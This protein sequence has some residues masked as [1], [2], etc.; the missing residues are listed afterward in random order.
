MASKYTDKAKSKWNDH[1]PGQGKMR[2]QV[3][4][5][6]HRNNDHKPS[7]GVRGQVS[8]LVHRNKSSDSSSDHVSVPLSQLKD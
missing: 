3:S 1:K 8:N 7:Q 2:G 5:L 6:V 4:N